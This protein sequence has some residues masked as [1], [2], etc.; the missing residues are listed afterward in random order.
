MFNNTAFKML[1]DYDTHTVSQ[2]SLKY[3]GI[4]NF[5]HDSPLKIPIWTL[6]ISFGGFLL[7]RGIL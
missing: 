1:S 5:I 6:K 3:G 2:K 7:S 4:E